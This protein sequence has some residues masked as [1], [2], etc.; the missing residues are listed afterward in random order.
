MWV[1]EPVAERLSQGGV[2]E[3]QE[4]VA[5]LRE[6]VRERLAARLA[7]PQTPVPPPR[8]DEVFFEGLAWL[9]ELAGKPE[10]A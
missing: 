8:Y 5:R 3:R 1:P 4:A 7:R 9:D 2:R 10:D 6:A